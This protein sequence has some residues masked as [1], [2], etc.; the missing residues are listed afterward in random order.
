MTS[1]RTETSDDRSPHIPASPSASFYA[2]SDDEEND[3]NMIKHTKHQAG[4]QLLRTKNKVYVHP[5]PSAK[6]NVEG[7]IAVM[8]EKIPTPTSPGSIKC[9]LLLAWLPDDKVG[10][11]TAAYNKVDM[12]EDELPRP[13]IVPPPPANVNRQ[14]GHVHGFQ[15]PVSQIFSII[16]RP[17]SIGWW[18][19]SIIIN[20]RSGES[21]PALFFH[22]SECKSTMEHRKRLQREN[23]S[24]GSENGSIFWGGDVVIDW[25][26]RYVPVER[27]AH[28]LGVYLIDP[29]EEDRIGFGND[30]QKVKNVLEGKHKD[31]SIQNKED[32]VV[33]ALNQ[34]RWNFLEKM[35]QVTTFARRTAQAAAENRNL[36]PQV[37][38]LLQ[39]PQV[40][41]VSEEFDSARLYLARWAMGIAEQSERERSQRLWTA[42]DVLGKEHSEVGE[43][44]ILDVES[45]VLSDQYKPVTQKEWDGFFN[46]RTGVLE[47]TVDEVKQ[48][49]FHGGF[50]SDAVRK[51][52]WLFLLE[53]YDWKSSK[54]ERQAK[55]NSLRDEFVKL[56]G[57]WWERLVENDNN[58]SQRDWWNDQRN[59]IEKDVHRTDRHIPLFAGEDIPHPNPDSP[60]AEQ[61]TNVHME[62][63]KDLL[64]TYNEYNPDLGYVQGMSDLL[65]PIYAVEQD[66]AVA[67]WAFVGFMSRME[68]NF[69]RDQSGMRFQLMTLD[70][71]CQLLDPKLYE[72]LQKVDSTNFFFFFRML[73]VWYKREFEFN[74]IL[75]LWE[76]LWTDYMSSQFHIF[77]AMAILEKHRN[78]IMDH[79]KGFDEVL[80]YI[81]ELSGM[82]DLQSTLI[83]AESLFRQFQRMVEAIDKKNNF[84]S[85]PIPRQR[86][87]QPPS[88]SDATHMSGRKSP[89]AT[90]QVSGRDAATATDVIRGAQA[91]CVITPELRSL[92]SRD[93]PKLNKAEVR[94]HGGGVGS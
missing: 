14:D 38:R 15:I 69:L 88:S 7:W 1:N 81:N 55:I 66:D 87:P 4:V 8:Q 20:T 50:E 11:V 24:I 64:L 42:K 67:F 61:G 73:L 51:E 84:P 22:D 31:L 60:F 72:H 83:R 30:S 26:K 3:Y 85:A 76:S 94:A 39:N 28:E 70:Q 86:L 12:A 19:G 77:I 6:D 80:K 41:T 33:A 44:E 53:V 62:Q 92:L 56:K 46:Q 74:D 23:F 65:A 59:R 71:L 43:F 48:R 40:Q 57:A 58:Y 5:T 36:P 49:I 37:R 68:R 35:S 78:V 13:P 18:F 2:L 27:A 21:F 47:K 32:P 82:I 34:A 52:A 91:E 17:P 79:L 54:D 90:A 16:V 10:D 89:A 63:M 45:L 9:G 29:S 75:R 93:P 25:L